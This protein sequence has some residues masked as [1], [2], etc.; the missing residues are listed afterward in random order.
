MST[1]TSCVLLQI[2]EKWGLGTTSKYNPTTRT[3]DIKV[4][5]S[6]PV[7]NNLCT[8]Q[9]AL[10]TVAGNTV[11]KTISRENV[12]TS[13]MT[14]TLMIA[15][16]YSAHLWSCVTYQVWL[17]KVQWFRKYN[18]NWNFKPLLW[19][20]PWTLVT[21]AWWSTMKLGLAAKETQEPQFWRY[22]CVQP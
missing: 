20:W 3:M 17:Q 9:L 2:G 13:P 5:G 18:I 7:Q 1:E 8:L 14:L 12:F 15:T 4:V 16:Q 19:P 22:S 21:L 11:T 6:R 10:S